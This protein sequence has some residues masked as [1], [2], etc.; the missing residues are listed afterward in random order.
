[1][2]PFSGKSAILRSLSW[3]CTDPCL[4]GLHMPCFLAKMYSLTVRDFLRL[5]DLTVAAIKFD[6]DS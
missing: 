2:V 5:P 3:I 6:N 4:F 1:M